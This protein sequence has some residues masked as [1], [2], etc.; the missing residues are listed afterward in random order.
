MRAGV[1]WWRPNAQRRAEEAAC[2]AVGKPVILSACFGGEGE[3]SQQHAQDRTEQLKAF[4]F[5]DPPPG[6]GK[7]R[8]AVR[9]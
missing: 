2:A 6:A 1:N 4:C 5:P 7:H 3:A 9:Q 8:T